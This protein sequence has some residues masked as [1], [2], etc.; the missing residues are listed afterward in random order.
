MVMQMLQIYSNFSCL[1]ILIELSNSVKPKLTIHVSKAH[2]ESVL[3]VQSV[4]SFFKTHV[5]VWYSS[6]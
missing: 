2:I 4:L 1:A 6:P 5:G 3:I